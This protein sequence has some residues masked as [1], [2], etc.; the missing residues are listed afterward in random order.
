[1]A[2]ARPSV[3]PPD[4]SALTPSATGL[5]TSAECP[6]CGRKSATRG[7]GVGTTGGQFGPVYSRGVTEGSVWFGT[8]SSG[9]SVN[10]PRLPYSAG[11]PVRL[12]GDG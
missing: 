10:W 12:V 11:V 8:A 2:S 7:T 9:M 3:S 4:P 5:R 1:M 6:A